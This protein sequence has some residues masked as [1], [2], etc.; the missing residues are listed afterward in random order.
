VTGRGVPSQICVRFDST[1]VA[2]ALAMVS[3]PLAEPLWLASE[4]F[5]T[6]A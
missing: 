6:T 3:V 2:D 4:T 5:A 1:T